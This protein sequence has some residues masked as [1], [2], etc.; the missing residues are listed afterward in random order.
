[1]IGTISAF[2]S[3]IWSNLLHFGQ[4]SAVTCDSGLPWGC[5][6]G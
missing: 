2:S 6:I 1:M 4:T 3:L 5:K